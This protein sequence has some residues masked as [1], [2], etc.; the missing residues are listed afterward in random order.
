MSNF[1]PGD[2]AL[3]VKCST[4]PALIGRVIKL[5]AYEGIAEYPG[6][7]IQ[8]FWTTHIDGRRWT[9]GET[10]LMPLEGDLAPEKQKT[11]EVPA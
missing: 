6:A 10:L 2:L 4:L 11:R 1:K 9:I 7:P 5:G 3:I 8:A